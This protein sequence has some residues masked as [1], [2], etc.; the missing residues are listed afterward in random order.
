MLASAGHHYGS[1]W[2]WETRRLWS[3]REMINF[4]LG[5]FAAHYRW[6]AQ[7]LTEA[8]IGAAKNRDG[9]V[10]QHEQARIK[11][12]LTSLRGE[13]A[14]LGLPTAIHR[15]DLALNAIGKYFETNDNLMGDLTALAAALDH[16]LQQ[17]YLYHYPSRHAAALQRIPKEWG[18]TLAAFPAAAGDITAAIDCCA[19]G[20]YTGSVFYLMRVLERGL[21]ELAA[22]VNRTFDV[23]QWHTIIEGIESDIR[24]Y[25]DHWSASAAKTEWM[26]FYSEAAKEFFYFKDGWRNHVSHNRAPY[27]ENQA[28]SVLEHVRGFM[29]HLSG[30]LSETDA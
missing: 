18:A 14:R 15:I 6:L 5:E 30:R 21:K 13:C 8:V 29:N 19:L 9:M 3:L 24:W 25:G 4:S 12:S 10:P 27:D 16:D 28:A 26:R 11:R 7:A 20:H 17:V 1:P 2:E 22:A 23:Q